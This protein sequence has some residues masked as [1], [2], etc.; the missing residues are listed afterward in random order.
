MEGVM[1]TSARNHFVGQI[2]EIKSGPVD[3][4]VILRTPDG[5][6]VV[7]IITRGSAEALGLARGSTAF[8]LVKA[9]SVIILVDYDSRKVSAR[10]NISGKISRIIKGAVSSEVEIANQSSP[11]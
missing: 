8:A 5:L 11:S 10:N 1:R 7:A 6:S 4:E 9:S 3:D 2:S